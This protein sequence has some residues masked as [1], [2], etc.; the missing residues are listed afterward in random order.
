MENTRE[1]KEAGRIIGNALYDLKTKYKKSTLLDAV[2]ESGCFI[3][4]IVETTEMGRTYPFIII[5]F[6]EK[7]LHD[8]AVKFKR[9]SVMLYEKFLNIKKWYCC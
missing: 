8:D 1:V 3:T 2:L 7:N 9:H 5:D 6:T 4:R